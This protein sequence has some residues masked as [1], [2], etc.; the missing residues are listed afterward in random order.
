MDAFVDLFGSGY[1]DLA[2]ALGVAKERIN[3][4]ADFPATYEKG[5]QGKGTGDAGGATE[6]GDL[7]SLAAAGDLEIPIAGVYPLERVRAAYRA[8][9]DRH[10]HGKIVLHP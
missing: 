3:T 7:A 4:I 10:T 2:L 5:V 6:L 1:V 8:L 9:S